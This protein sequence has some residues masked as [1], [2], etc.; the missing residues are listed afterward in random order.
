MAMVYSC[1][2]ILTVD[3]VFFRSPGVFHSQDSF[4]L[5]FRPR[6][7]ET[8]S[9]VVAVGVFAVQVLANHLAAVRMHHIYKTQSRQTSSKFSVSHCLQRTHLQRPLL[10][11]SPTAGDETSRGRNP[12]NGRRR[13]F[14]R[15]RHRLDSNTPIDHGHLARNCSIKIIKP[16]VKACHLNQKIDPTWD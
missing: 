4:P 6:L 9:G 5:T 11:M 7:R 13:D 14:E 2:R 1:V 15:R 12:E 8:S 10:E 3:V 16:A